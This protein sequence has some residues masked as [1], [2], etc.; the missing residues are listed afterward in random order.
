MIQ[1]LASQLKSSVSAPEIVAYEDP[2]RKRQRAKAESAGVDQSLPESQSTGMLPKESTAELS[3]KQARFEVFRF[4]LKGLDKAGRE[5]AEVSEL[6]RLGAKP[7][8]RPCLSYSELKVQRQAEKQEALQAK[9]MEKI[10]GVR[11]GGRRPGGQAK[12]Q[13][14]K[15]IGTKATKSKNKGSKTGSGFRES[16]QA[17]VGKFDGGMLKLSAKDISKIK[18]K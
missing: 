5:S 3:M 11:T 12:G 2:R 14:R 16:I 4:G 13:K 7:P 18:G 6:I 9:A 10:S 1:T 17:K 8:K 15:T